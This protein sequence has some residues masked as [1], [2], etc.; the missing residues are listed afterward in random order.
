MRS[1]LTVSKTRVPQWPVIGPLLI[2]TYIN[3]FPTA[4]KLFKYLMYS[5]GTTLC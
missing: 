2:F 4:S 3:D 1:D 5:Y